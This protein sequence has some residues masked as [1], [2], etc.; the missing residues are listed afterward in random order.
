[1]V[2]KDREKLK[3]EVGEDLTQRI[4]GFDTESSDA[5]PTQLSLVEVAG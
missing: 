1:V 2:I 3:R 4:E 5:G